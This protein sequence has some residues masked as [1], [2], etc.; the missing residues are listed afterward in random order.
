MV[1][2][3]PDYVQNWRKFLR[4]FEIRGALPVVFK[5]VG[6]ERSYFTDVTMTVPHAPTGLPFE[7]SKLFDM[8]PFVVSK[9]DMIGL[10]QKWARFMYIHELR[11]QTY[12]EGVRVDIPYE[13]H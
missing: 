8:P 12:L 4:N 11:E 10:A 13:D 2:E 1:V 5:V 3:E 7:I 6:R 9:S